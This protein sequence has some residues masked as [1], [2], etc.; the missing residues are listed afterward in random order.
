MAPWP[1]GAQPDPVPRPEPSGRSPSRPHTQSPQP[2]AQFLSPE[3]PL[4]PPPPKPRALPP[5]SIGVGTSV[6]RGQ[7]CPPHAQS[8]REPGPCSRVLVS[9]P[10]DCSWPQSSPQAP[11]AQ[12][13]V[14]GGRGGQGLPVRRGAGRQGGG[15][16][17]GSLSA[18]LPGGGALRLQGKLF[19]CLGKYVNGPFRSEGKVL[20]SW[21]TGWAQ[22]G[23]LCRKP[24]FL[25]PRRRGP[26][27]QLTPGPGPG[28]GGL[29]G[30]RPTWV[31]SD[32]SGAQRHQACSLQTFDL[33]Y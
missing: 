10:Q 33:F 12:M 28:L 20:E 19:M 7:P 24:A 31:S 23:E 21:G 16:S 2:R 14:E 3:A 9:W 5:A 30:I 13:Q 26:A 11:Q 15:G 25:P 17:P 1:G 32:S 22:N 18:L 4:R 29:G 6:N 8:P 27:G